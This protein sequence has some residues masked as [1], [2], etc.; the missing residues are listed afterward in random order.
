MLAS[1]S[2]LGERARGNRWS[3]TVAM[4][5][6][7]SALGGAF[8][9]AVFGALGA[10]V[11]TV[12][13]WSHAGGALLGAAFALA[14]L[15]ADLGIRG[16]RYPTIHRQVNELW[17]DRY[18]SWVYAVGFGFQLGLALVTIV[19][20]TSTYVVLALEFFSAS[21]WNG[22]A[23]GAVFG[24]ARALP[25]LAMFP[26]RDADRLFAAHRRFQTLAR[27]FDRLTRAAMAVAAVALTAVAV[28]GAS[29]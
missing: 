23:I 3:T 12:L 4:Y 10:L 25:L 21:L 17:L 16:W 11:H 2:P 14:A 18:R 15:V 26:A 1:I 19:T 22:V 27:P 28:T 8:T 5:V 9:G 13:P 24:V 6:V 7:A 20:S 29:A